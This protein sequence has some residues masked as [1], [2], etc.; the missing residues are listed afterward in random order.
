MDVH[1]FV[2]LGPGG[3]RP[4]AGDGP[5]GGNRGPG[6]GGETEFVTIVEPLRS[7]KP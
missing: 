3:A 5:A 7:I 6:L 4:D 1:V 2:V